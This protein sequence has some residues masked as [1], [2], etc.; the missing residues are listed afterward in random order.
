MIPQNVKDYVSRHFLGKVK[1]NSIFHAL[2]PPRTFS[3]R[4]AVDTH[5]VWTSENIRRAVDTHPIRIH[6]NVAGSVLFERKSIVCSG[7]GFRFAAQLVKVRGARIAR[8]APEEIKTRK[9]RKLTIKVRE[10]VKRVTLLP[11]ERANRLRWQ[12]MRPR[13]DGEMILAWF[14]PIVEDA[15]VKLTLN[16]QRGTLLI[17]YN[18]QSRRF[19]AKGLY[20]YR[21]LGGRENLEWRWL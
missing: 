19:D 15:I 17:W 10:G 2:D 18:P 21:R 7:G 11:Q 3:L 9:I 6:L 1:I 8:Y 14:G 5:P 16:K 4:R 13:R 12:V 20:M